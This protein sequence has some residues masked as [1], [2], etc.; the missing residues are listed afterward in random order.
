MWHVH[1]FSRHVQAWSERHVQGMFQTCSDLFENSPDMSKHVPIWVR[2]LASLEVE[3]CLMLP[4]HG[5]FWNFRVLTSLEVDLCKAWHKNPSM[6]L[7][8][9]VINQ[10]PHWNAQ[11]TLRQRWL[12]FKRFSIE[13]WLGWKWGERF[14]TLRNI[15]LNYIQY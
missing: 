5:N 7:F 2:G 14:I 10:N 11:G 13:V 3:L 4:W 8:C 9:G 12:S 15:L 1:K 6:V